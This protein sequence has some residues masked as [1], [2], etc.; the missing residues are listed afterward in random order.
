MGK[1]LVMK[2]AF[3]EDAAS[4]NQKMLDRAYKIENY[5]FNHEIGGAR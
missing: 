5:L 3:L 2:C 1:R 4:K